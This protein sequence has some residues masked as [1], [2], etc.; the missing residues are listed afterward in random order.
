MVVLEVMVVSP[1]FWM[2]APK[3]NR[4]TLWAN[5]QKDKTEMVNDENSYNGWTNYE[6]WNIALWLG[7]DEGYYKIAKEYGSQGYLALAASLRDLGVLETPDKVA[8]ND[9]GLD[10]E[11]L[12]EMLEE[13]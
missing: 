2:V 3:K 6:T 5:N 13:L 9:S 11:E 12:D 1:L 10:I 8:F 7:N 4:E